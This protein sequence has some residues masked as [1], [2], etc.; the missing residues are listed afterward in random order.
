MRFSIGEELGYLAEYVELDG[1]RVF[2]QSLDVV[3]RWVDAYV[4]ATEDR[5]L[6]PDD[7]CPR[8][9]DANFE[10]V[11]RRYE[12]E[13]AVAFRSAAVISR[14]P[15]RPIWHGCC[16]FWTDESNRLDKSEGDPVCPTC[17][18]PVFETTSEEWF[19]LIDTYE[20]D[21]PGYENFMLSGPGRKNLCRGRGFPTDRV[22]K[23][24]VESAAK[25]VDS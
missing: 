5:P 4:H 23:E 13:V 20:K 19:D 8:R 7:K 17:G 2:V 22:W 14:D 3:E 25:K 9:L 18:S 16:T 24:Y 12:G 21:R 1:V 6:R 11:I 15:M 10:P